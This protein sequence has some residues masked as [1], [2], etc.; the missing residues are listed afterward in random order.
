M[1]RESSMMRTLL[2]HPNIDEV[3]L[4]HSNPATAFEF[5]HP[6]VRNVDSI[7]HNKEMG[8]SLRFYFCQMAAHPWVLHLDDDMEFTTEALNEMLIE[9][10]RN[11]K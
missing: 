8:L 4:L 5:V 9:Y 2:S 1:I 11:R 10:G 7:E 3:L 6:K